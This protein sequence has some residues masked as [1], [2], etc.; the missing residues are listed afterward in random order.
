MQT[1][2]KIALI[3]AI[4]NPNLGDEALLQAN[5]QLINKIY[6]KYAT[7]YIF[8]KNASYTSLYEN[9]S[10]TMDIDIIP[11]SFLHQITVKANYDVNKMRDYSRELF[12]Y[13]DK[14]NSGHHNNVIFDSL[15]YIFEDIDV[16]HIIGGGYINSL[17]PDMLEEVNIASLLAKRFSVP[18]F[19]TRQ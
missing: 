3:G 14:K 1:K 7:V 19:F 12:D 18:Y 2:K 6:G 4:A 11:V 13:L 16:L 8:T 17:W 5:L 10:T 9:F 15:K